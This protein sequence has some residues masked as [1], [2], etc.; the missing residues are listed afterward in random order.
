MVVGKHGGAAAAAAEAT[1][2]RQLRAHAQ[3]LGLVEATVVNN[4]GVLACTAGEQQLLARLVLAAAASA[5]ALRRQ[6]RCVDGVGQAG[7][8]GGGCRRA[9]VG[10]P[11]SCAL[12]GRN[13]LVIAATCFQAF[14]RMPRIS[15]ER[16]HGKAIMPCLLRLHGPQGPYAPGACR[17]DQCCSSATGI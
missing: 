15:A 13:L 3:K 7:W 17:L 6:H 12:P 1:A 8:R 11:R 16:L 2:K 9:T 5:A 10:S 14:L 4:C